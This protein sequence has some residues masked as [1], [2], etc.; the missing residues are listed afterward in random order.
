MID[1]DRKNN[2]NAQKKSEEILNENQGLLHNMAKSLLKHEVIDA[3]R[4]SKVIRW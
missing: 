4:Y 3:E 1:E 2:R